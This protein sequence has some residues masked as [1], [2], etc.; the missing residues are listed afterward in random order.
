FRLPNIAT[1]E[2]VQRFGHA[3][4]RNLLD[5][6]LGADV[7]QVR[8]A[9][10]VPA[11][12][13]RRVYAHI[14]AHL[15]YYSATIIAAG[16]PAE[17]FFALAKLRD[18]GGRPL[19]DVIENIVVDRVGNYVAFPLRSID[20]TTPEWRSALIANVRQPARASQEFSVTLPVPG[21]WLRSE[22]FPAHLAADSDAGAAGAA[23][24]EEVKTEG[25]TERR[26]RG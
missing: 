8:G 26:K 24:A 11:A 7:D 3:I 22:L 25:R 12:V 16:D 18:P 10:A 23:G 19:T 13:E 20:D 14:A 15:P 21:V 9:D 17:R 2:V 5:R 4:R 1:R 6:N